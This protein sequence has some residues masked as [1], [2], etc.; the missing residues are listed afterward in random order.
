VSRIGILE[1]GGLLGKELR[2]QLESRPELA[3]EL[4][5]MTQRAEEVG[6]LTEIAGAAA[7]VQ[8]FVPED[9]E[10]LDL[11]FLCEPREAELG[12]LER[13]PASLATIVV[14]PTVT[15]PGG[16]PVIAGDGDAEVERGVVLVSPHAAVVG[17]AHLLRPLLALGLQDAVATLLLPASI[18][19]Q[20]ALEEVFEQTRALL[21]FK[22]P[23]SGRR[24]S[25][26][27]AFNVLPGP[28]DEAVIVEQLAALLGASLTPPPLG[29]GEPRLAVHT[30]QA[31]VFHG[32]SLSVFC[33]LGSDTSPEDVTAALSGRE[34]VELAETPE[35]VG[36]VA[37]A[38]GE[39]ILVGEIRSAV[40]R[41]GA[42][43]LWAALDNLTRGGATNAIEIAAQLSVRS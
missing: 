42:F 32:L 36:P 21:E 24:F 16:R 19:D 28:P 39:T 37:A 23:A 1:P 13:L 43:W 15:I 2:E 14:S 35:A 17:L 30:L 25:Q 18:Y 11:L 10:T 26:Q 4:R 7:M 3:T 38:T 12:V 34:Q 8:P 9:L 20:D 33:Q 41:P 31:G 27:L 40:G 6:T 29:R 5:L 22:Q